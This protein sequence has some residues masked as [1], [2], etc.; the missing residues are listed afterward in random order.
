MASF[1]DNIF[2][3]ASKNSG[4]TIQV[5]HVT[6]LDNEVVA[7]EQGLRSGTAPLN[8]S[9]STFAGLSVSGGSTLATLSVSGE[10]TV[11]NL[12]IGSTSGGS[13]LTVRGSTTTL[14][15]SVS[16]RGYAQWNHG[17]VTLAS[18]SSMTLGSTTRGFLFA[19]E[20][21]NVKG[22][23]F[24]LRGSGNAVSIVSDPDTEMS[25][26]LGGAAG[27]TGKLVVGFET[28]HYTLE[29]RL[30]ASVDVRLTLIGG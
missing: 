20:N 30:G 18:G 21:G 15:I 17:I 24:Y 13:T 29:N 12:A 28:D 8:S 2:S 25:T 3:P 6:D 9:N 14:N 16:T 10:S 4:D 5:S 26:V 23:V 7:L 22:G 1:P 11:A 19:D 27:S